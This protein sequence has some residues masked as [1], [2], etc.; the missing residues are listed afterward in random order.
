MPR[1]SIPLIRFGGF[2]EAE[3]LFILA[4]EG[5][6]TEKQYFLG[7]R[8]SDLFNDSGFI[9]IINLPRPKK[10]GTDPV[11]V[12]SLL[13]KAKSEY[14]FK[15]TDEF[16][17]IVDRDD[18]EDMHYH[19]FDEI[20]TD[21]EKEGNFYLALSNPCFEIWIIL[22]FKDPSEITSDELVGIFRNEK[23]GAKRYIS[24][25]IGDIFGRGYT[26][27]APTQLMLPHT[28]I[29]IER[30]RQLD[31][32]GDKYPK[33]VGTHVYKLVEKLIK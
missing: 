31:L 14:R 15:D 33:S 6:Q 10:V 9:E 29:A 32:N 26:K 22:H 30:A 5:E 8:N 25:F 4:F 3:K 27:K 20:V 19:N 17:L 12:K 11:S 1:E 24:V 23:V 28:N 2:L 16:W 18:W 13:K 21:C 7:L